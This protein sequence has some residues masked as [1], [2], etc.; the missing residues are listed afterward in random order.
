MLLYLK[1]LYGSS[2]E[3]RPLRILLVENAKENRIVVKAFLKKTPHIIDVAENGRIGVDKFLSGAYDLILMDMRMAVMD[4][5]TPTG[6]IRKWETE[7]RK[8]PVPIIALTAH[9]L[10]ED[11]RKCLDAG[12]T[13]YLPK[14]LKKQD[15]LKKIQ[16]YSGILYLDRS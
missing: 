3:V 2:P 8:G 11:R 12:C 14:P 4:G 9:A 10:M 1:M 13:D 16:D 7:Q 5:Y 15:L 6:M